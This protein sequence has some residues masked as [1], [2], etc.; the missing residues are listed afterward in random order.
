MKKG[1]KVDQYQKLGV[2]PDKRNVRK[3][4]KPVNTSMFPG[5]WV[6]IAPILIGNCLVLSTQHSDGS[7]SKII[8][9]LLHYYE[10]K[11]ASVLGYTVDDALAMNGGDIA[12]AGFVRGSWIATDVL[13]VCLPNKD[14]KVVLMEETA[15]RIAELK[16]LYEQ[17]GIEIVFLGG[18][19]A[20][21]PDQVRSAT[22]DMTVTAFAD[23]DDIIKGE[24]KPGDIIRGFQSNGRAVWEEK[25][26]SGLM[27]NGLTLA[28]PALM[29]TM[30]NA[31]YPALRRANRRVYK[32]RFRIDDRL[33]DLEGLTVGEALI[34]PTRQW[35]FV[36]RRLIEELKEMRCLHQLHGISFNTGGGATKIKNLGTGGISYVKNMIMPAPIFSLIQSESQEKWQNMYKIFNCGI[37]L[38]IIGEDKPELAAALEMTGEACGIRLYNLGRCEKF[39]GPGNQVILNTHF[40]EF[41]Y[42]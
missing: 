39:A 33:E 36:I 18:E 28:R 27:S 17:Q 38:D 35:A 11:D 12:A 25:I 7:G 8:Q 31:K 21:L 26:N 20:D 6:N 37:G 1:R 41:Q 14:D 34:S 24:V 4:F 29:H 13:N 16:R 32:G 23:A 40:G 3:A 2:D 9:N 19:T 5:S 42:E 10:T 22:L 15:K 30:Y